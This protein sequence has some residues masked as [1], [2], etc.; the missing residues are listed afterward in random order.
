MLGACKP[1]KPT[2]SPEAEA[3]AEKAAPS[4]EKPKSSA[5]EDATAAL[6][7]QLSREAL[8][9]LKPFEFE[10][11]GLAGQAFL[12]K[13][14]EVRSLEDGKWVIV[15]EY[16]PDGT[17]MECLLEIGI[18]SFG[19][20]MGRFLDSAINQSENIEG[21]LTSVG[22]VFVRQAKYAGLSQLVVYRFKKD[23]SVVGYYTMV[24]THGD[25]WTL[26][27][28]ADSPGFFKT[29]FAA[30]NK[31]ADS[32]KLSSDWVGNLPVAYSLFEI[33]V[34]DTRIGL[35]ERYR[36]RLDKSES[37]FSQISVA[38]GKPNENFQVK[39][40]FSIQRFT[41]NQLRSGLMDLHVNGVRQASFE[42]KR[43]A[44]GKG[45]RVTD[46]KSENKVEREVKP[47]A[48]VWNE[49]RIKNCLRDA[50]AGK[51][52]ECK[53]SSVS[54]TGTQLTFPISSMTV[55]DKKERSFDSS[56]GPFNGVQWFDE[57]LD[58]VSTKIEGSAGGRTFSMETRRLWPKPDAE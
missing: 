57:N 8:E 35:Q 11:D 38:A 24:S 26:T 41:G 10:E 14:P 53:V 46:H 21:H 6:R 55:K 18:E 36:Y 28:G 58:S 56:A 15:G 33:K 22:E 40:Q 4:E 25:S 19:E 45:L 2:T 3:K 5:Q 42:Y 20:T 54:L 47:E 51:K 29:L 12:L 9:Q 50:L 7:K 34:G 37:Q 49:G 31:L 43:D 13:A 44:K 16:A 17:E 48:P 23:P 30:T 52:K 32:I 39:S 27:C 1:Q